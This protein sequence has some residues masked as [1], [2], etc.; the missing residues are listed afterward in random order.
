MSLQDLFDLSGRSAIVT[1]G[2]AGLGRQLAEGLAEAGA[3]L[4]LCARN[5]ER[6]RE[7]ASELGRQH[8]VKAVGV[9][10][11]VRDPDAIRSVVDLA[12]R[13]LGSIDILVSNAGTSW[14]APAV[15]YPLEGWRKV[16]DVNLTG[17]FLF[18]Q[19]AGRAM[20]EQGD[21]GKI[22]NIASVAAFRG[23][24]SELMDAVAYNASKGGVVSLTR[25]LAA[26]W[27]RFGINVNAIAPGWFPTEM[28]EL[29]LERHGDLF[30]ER[31]PLRR[32]GGPEDLKG[33]IVFLASPASDFVTGQTLLVDGGMSIA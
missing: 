7:A 15:D 24:P 17:V 5:A 33:A 10:C 3:S 26:K 28:S 29:L 21:G 30:L 27:A 9:A 12:K 18:A 23:A 11:D 1:G 31:I 25:D 14:G 8:G 19:S 13:E 2:G 6:C 16:I 20:I 22:V 4:V 32:F